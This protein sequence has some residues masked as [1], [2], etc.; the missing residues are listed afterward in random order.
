MDTLHDDQHTFSFISRSFLLRM[1]VVSDKICRANQ[2]T[3]FVFS[4]FFFENGAVDE[5]IRKNIVELGR[6]QMTIWHMLIAR[7][8]PKAMNTQNI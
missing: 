5:I 8:I 1:T 7:W 2:K 4:N 3:H 6:L